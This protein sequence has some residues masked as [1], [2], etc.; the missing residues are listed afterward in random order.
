V[1][2]QEKEV[3]HGWCQVQVGSC[4]Q[5]TSGSSESPRILANVTDEETATETK[6]HVMRLA[7]ANVSLAWLPRLE[8]ESWLMNRSTSELLLGPERFATDPSAQTSMGGCI[9]AW[10]TDRLTTMSAHRMD[11]LLVCSCGA[12]VCRP[13]PTHQSTRMSCQSWW[14]DGV[15]SVSR[16][17]CD[18]SSSGSSTGHVEQWKLLN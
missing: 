6:E 5:G 15:I 9:T 11:G 10:L 3:E 7:L 8:S 16:Q 4:D 14:R 2:D 1:G 13:S 18:N 17:L 12:S